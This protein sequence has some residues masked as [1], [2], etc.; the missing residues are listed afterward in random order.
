VESDLAKALNEEPR[1]EAARKLLGKEE[2]LLAATACCK[3]PR[4]RARSTLEPAA[5]ELVKLTEQVSVL[6]E[7]VGRAQRAWRRVDRASALVW[8][9]LIVAL[10]GRVM[11]RQE[12]RGI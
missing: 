6:S 8:P 10:V 5:S 4:P 11:F 7:I 2:A 3:P 1:P 12:C 9:K